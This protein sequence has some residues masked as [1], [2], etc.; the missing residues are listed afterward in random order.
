[1]KTKIIFLLL[2]ASFIFLSAYEREQVS[3][4]A[5]RYTR[6]TEGDSSS[7]SQGIILYNFNIQN[8]NVDGK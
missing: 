7:L 5:H 8:L 3:R 4:Y 6:L 2:L 1:M